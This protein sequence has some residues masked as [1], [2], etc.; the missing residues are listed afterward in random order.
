MLDMEAKFQELAVVEEG[1][2][3]F[4]GRVEAF[5]LALGEFFGA[6]ATEGDFAF[7]SKFFE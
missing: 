6:A 3:A 5:F 2:K 7:R 1:L 4:T